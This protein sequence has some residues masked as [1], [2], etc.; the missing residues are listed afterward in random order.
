MKTRKKFRLKVQVPKED[1]EQICLASWLDRKGVLYTASANGG[2][3]HI[4]EALKFR[5]MGVKKGYPD[6]TIPIA[7]KAYHGLYIELKRVSG[8]VLSD[9]QRVWLRKLA[10]EGNLAVRANGFLEAKKIIEDY[11]GDWKPDDTIMD[12]FSDDCES[13]L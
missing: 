13:L 12:D 7:R 4:G 5:R 9:E 6:I 1:Y 11:L 3:R 8:G 2:S 10:R